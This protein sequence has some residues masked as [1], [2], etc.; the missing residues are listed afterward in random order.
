MILGASSSTTAHFLKLICLPP[1]ILTDL[2]RESYG[3][4]VLAFILRAIIP[5]A[6]FLG[7]SELS[8]RISISSYARSGLEITIDLKFPTS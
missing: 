6:P 5:R 8:P 4:M 7:N 1:S 2:S 3:D